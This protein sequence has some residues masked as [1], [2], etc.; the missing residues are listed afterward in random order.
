MVPFIAPRP[1]AASRRRQVLDTAAKRNVCAFPALFTKTHVQIPRYLVLISNSKF[2]QSP[3][4][5]A[6]M[7]IFAS[8]IEFKCI[9]LPKLSA[10]T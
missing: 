4:L 3:N 5:T 6:D 7:Y 8:Q 2:L 9:K 1:L 10:S